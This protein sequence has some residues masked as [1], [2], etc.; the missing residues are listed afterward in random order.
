MIDKWLIIDREKVQCWKSSSGKVQSIFGLHITT[1]HHLPHS[2]DYSRWMPPSTTIHPLPHPDFVRYKLITSFT[3]ARSMRYAL[4]GHPSGC[5]ERAIG[6]F[7]ALRFALYFPVLF[8]RF[9]QIIFVLF[10][11]RMCFVVCGFPA[12]FPAGSR[13]DSRCRQFVF[14]VGSTK[15]I[16]R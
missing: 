4:N 9:Q 2:T 16:C 14:V 6:W 11:V 8:E 15:F 5:V 3:A 1:F 10:C 7:C 13:W 12:A